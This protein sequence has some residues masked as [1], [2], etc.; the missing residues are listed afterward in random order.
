MYCNKLEKAQ[1]LPW[2]WAASVRTKR[3]Y[4]NIY[5]PNVTCA[6]YLPQPMFYERQ[7]LQASCVLDKQCFTPIL[8]PTKEDKENVPADKLQIPL[9]LSFSL[10][11]WNIVTHW[12]LQKH[13]G[14]DTIK[15]FIK[16]SQYIRVAIARV[17]KPICA[18]CYANL[19][20]SVI[21]PNLEW[22]LG[23]YHVNP[24]FVDNMGS[25]S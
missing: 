10:S 16:H 19:V 21:F 22:Y 9:I 4:L 11:I 17:T 6:D 8:C 25:R 12:Q 13:F 18:G 23:I 14:V 15:L 24:K 3:A 1:R 7:L 20:R 2:W 5:S